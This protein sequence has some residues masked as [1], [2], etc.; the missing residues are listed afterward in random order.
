M[1]YDLRKSSPTYRVVDAGG[2]DVP[3][4]AIYPVEEKLFINVEIPDDERHES[5]SPFFGSPDSKAVLFA[6]LHQKKT[7]LVLVKVD[8]SGH[9]ALV[10]TVDPLKLCREPEKPGYMPLE[11]ARLTFARTWKVGDCGRVRILV[12]T[13]PSDRKQ[14]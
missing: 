3:G 1:I 12:Q 13:R 9:T 7:D 4:R 10:R 14:R 11:S 8:N 6:D 5:R 2:A